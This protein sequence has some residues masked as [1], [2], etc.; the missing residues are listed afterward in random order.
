MVYS[1]RQ[2]LS[3]N[4]VP[5]RF[6]KFDFTLIRSA[7]GF[8]KRTP[9]C[10]LITSKTKKSWFAPTHFRVFWLV[11][12][13]VSV[14]CDWPERLLWSSIGSRTQGLSFFFCCFYGSIQPKK[15]SSFRWDPS[16]IRGTL[17]CC[18]SIFTLIFSRWEETLEKKKNIWGSLVQN[19]TEIH[20]IMS[21]DLI[22]LNL[23]LNCRRRLREHTC[24]SLIWIKSHLLYPCESLTCLCT[25]FHDKNLQMGVREK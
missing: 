25:L 12:W 8:E 15:T 1:E 18:F 20:G 4:N 5:F 9:L 11:Q 21:V 16:Q 23:K 19:D 22:H 6:V 10:H 17:F 3:C 2:L 7:I 24:L 14:L 13:I